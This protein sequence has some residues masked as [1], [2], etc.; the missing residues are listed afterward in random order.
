MRHEVVSNKVYSLRGVP[1]AVR[2]G[3]T[4]YFSG[5]VA[6][7]SS[8]QIVGEGDLTAQFERALDNMRL[9]VE[10]E[11]GSIGDIVKLNMYVLDMEGFK[12]GGGQV[13]KGFF[14]QRLPALLGVEVS[15]LAV[16]GLLIELDGIAVV[17]AS[18]T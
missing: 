1:S 11:G 4:L 5:Q 14:G 15:G 6:F 17:G 7:D 9:V 10:G 3:A 16:A 13:L 12:D 2:V 18:K 8:G